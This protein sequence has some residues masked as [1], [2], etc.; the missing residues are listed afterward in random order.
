MTRFSNA[1]APGGASQYMDKNTAPCPQCE[2][3]ASQIVR[4]I[5]KKFCENFLK[6]FS[7][8]FS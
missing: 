8:S 1:I 6:K 2:T 3:T 5:L 7:F 4:K